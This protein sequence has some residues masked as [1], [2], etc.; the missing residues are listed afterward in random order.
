MEKLMV[1]KRLERFP[2]FMIH[3]V[4]L[5]KTCSLTALVHKTKG[6]VV[7]LTKV[8]LTEFWGKNHFNSFKC[9]GLVVSTNITSK[10]QHSLDCANCL[11]SI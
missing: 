6:V 8:L 9:G 2:G 4:A 7:Y 11:K 3:T 10:E 5:N 1:K